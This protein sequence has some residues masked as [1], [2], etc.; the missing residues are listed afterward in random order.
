MG[1][2]GFLGQERNYP[3]V[4]KEVAALVKGLKRWYYIVGVRTIVEIDAKALIGMVN[5]PTITDA[6]SFRW[7]MYVRQF[8]IEFRHI[9]GKDNVVGDGLSRQFWRRKGRS[10]STQNKHCCPDLIGN[11]KRKWKGY[12]L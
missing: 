4:K 10:T 12:C 2:W 3:Q 7:L 11:W 8:D 5:D 1:E 9:K 6:T